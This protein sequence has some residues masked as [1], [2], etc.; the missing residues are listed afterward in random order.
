[1]KK[2]VEAMIEGGKATPAPPIGPNLAPLGVNVGQII[3][4]INKKTASFAGMQVPV[5]II[6]ET[7]DRSFEI[8]VGTP[9]VSALLKKEAGVDK[10]SPNPQT[11]YVAD[12]RIE[13]VIKIAKSKEN[14]MLGRNLQARVKQIVGSC[15]S[16]GLLV[17]GMPPREAVASI[18][19]G[20]F[21]EKIKAE[22]TELSA[23]ELAQVKK[24]RERLKAEF[25]AR[26]AQLTET[27]KKIIEANPGAARSHVKAKL[28][29]VKIPLALID[30]LL[31]A[32]AA[33]AAAAAAPA[34]PA[35]GKK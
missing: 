15:D 3:A 29:E 23:E 16:M 1:M 18:N 9:P 6:V 32:E 20:R 11:D 27:A 26:R 31:P 25:E 8:E 33:G 34:K 28:L 4:E 17:E 7:E 13:Q 19:A 24:E 35:G 22:K 2:T 5:K 10:A 12:L 21:D 30:E 14:V